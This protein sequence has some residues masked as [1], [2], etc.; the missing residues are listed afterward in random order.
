MFL[1]AGMFVGLMTLVIVC[2][3]DGRMRDCLEERWIEGVQ[4]RFIVGHPEWLECAGSCSS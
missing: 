1:V 2:R 3:D 4:T